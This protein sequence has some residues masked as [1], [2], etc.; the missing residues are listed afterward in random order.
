MNNDYENV[1]SDEEDFESG[2]FIE[3]IKFETEKANR[4]RNFYLRDLKSKERRGS[5]FID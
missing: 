4:E 3:H 2:A 5:I 1:S